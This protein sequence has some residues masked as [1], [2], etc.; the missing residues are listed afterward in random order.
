MKMEIGM[1]DQHGFIN[2]KCGY[3]SRRSFNFMAAG[4]PVVIQD[5]GFFKLYQTEERLLTFSSL[6]EANEGIKKGKW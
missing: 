2:S 5:T 3:L 1:A 6:E 4:K